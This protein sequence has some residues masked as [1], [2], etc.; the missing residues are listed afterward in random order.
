MSRSYR[1]NTFVQD[2]GNKKAGKKF[3]NRRVRRRMKNIDFFSSLGSYKKLYES[4][5]ICDYTWGYLSYQDFYHYNRK[6]Y[7]SDEECWN[8]FKRDWKCK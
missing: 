6:Y 3:A 2:Q 5:D 1:K 4:W 7:N 8:A